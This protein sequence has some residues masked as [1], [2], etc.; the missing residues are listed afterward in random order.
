MRVSY[1]AASATDSGAQAPPNPLMYVAAFGVVLCAVY[2]AIL[3]LNLTEPLFGATIVAL[4]A[5]GFAVSL[6][7]RSNIS[8]G[9]VLAALVGSVLGGISLVAASGGFG[10]QLFPSQGSGEVHRDLGAFLCWLLVLLSFAQL[11]RGWL[12][13]TCVPA[14]AIMGLVGT[15][16]SEA[17]FM[18]LFIVFVFLGTFLVVHDQHARFAEAR[19]SSRVANRNTLDPRGAFVAQ[20]SIVAACGLGA[21]LLAQFIAP[22]LHAVGSQL[23]PLSAVAGTESASD[24]RRQSNRVTVSESS[25]L[26]IG[27]GPE[28]ASDTVLMRVRAEHGSYWRGATF[29]QYTGS[30]WRTNLV[31]GLHVGPGPS[32]GFPSS[33]FDPR[34]RQSAD[35]LVPR[36]EVNDTPGPTHTLQ[37]YV[38]LESAGRFTELYG[39][40]EPRVFRL[41]SGTEFGPPLTATADEAG[42][43]TLSRGIAATYYEVESDIVEW[44]PDLLREASGGIPERIRQV[45]TTLPDT[46][47]VARIR[48]L[49]R[50]ITRN[51][52][53]AYDKV[54]ALKAYLT[55]VCVYNLEAEALRADGSDMVAAFVFDTREGECKLFGS[56]LAVMC[57]SIGLPAR[58]AS[59][60][61]SGEFDSEGQYYLV[62]ERD[63]H[64]WT[65]VYFPGYGWIAFDATTDARDVTPRDDDAGLLDNGGFLASIFRRGIAPPIA[66]GGG[67]LLLAYVLLSEFVIK[68]FRRRGAAEGSGLSEEARSVLRSYSALSARLRRRG[69]A[70]RSHETPAEFASRLTA[71]LASGDA[72]RALERMTLLVVAARYEGAPVSAVE[73]REAAGLVSSIVKG[74]ATRRRWR[75]QSC[76]VQGRA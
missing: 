44:T 42:R 60:F 24:R 14:A 56:A 40:S 26:R 39:A 71:H 38:R 43:V 31:N 74:V 23:V 69:L 65:E 67:L 13:F 11:S 62:R 68:R 59:G 41:M 21:I 76:L 47:G 32:R 48:D 52:P 27:T 73:A 72:Q 57:R 8:T 2:A 20:L 35:I 45:Y 63:K 19:G 15:V 50:T 25:D 61:L 10:S 70:R 30:G 1:V 75:P 66:L 22:P 54:E 9:W 49:A 34:M 18:W 33:M 6:F 29:D 4:S 53:N 58:V 55:Q 36:G 37:Q 28:A 7:T 64:L 3:G 12:L 17:P 5:I 46:P 51:S 16:Y